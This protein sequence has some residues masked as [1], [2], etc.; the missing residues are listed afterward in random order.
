MRHTPVTQNSVVFAHIRVGQV[1]YFSRERVGLGP[2][3]G[4][5]NQIWA[6]LVT[7]S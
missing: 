6:A 4:A 7:G 1:R 3:V 2:E 5:W